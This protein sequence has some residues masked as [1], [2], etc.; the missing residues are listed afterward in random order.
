MT[1]T[2]WSPAAVEWEGAEGTPCATHDAFA[3]RAAAEAWR[4]RLPMC[5]GCRGPLIVRRFDEARR[6]P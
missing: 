5:E 2:R 3:T 6:R 1:C 4:R